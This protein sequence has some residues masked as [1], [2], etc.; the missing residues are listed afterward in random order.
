VALRGGPLL[1]TPAYANWSSSLE[2]DGTKSVWLGVYAEGRQSAQSVFHQDSYSAKVSYRPRD[3]LTFSLAAEATRYSD[4]HQF[5][6]T[7]SLQSAS[8]YIVSHLEAESRSLALRAEWHLRPELSL[9][10]YGNP[11]GSTVRFGEYRQVLAPDA[12]NFSQRLSPALRASSFNG[13]TLLDADGDGAA[14]FALDQPDWND[15]SFHSNL[16]LRWEYR[17]GSTLYLAW[18]QQRYGGNSA[19]NE[20]AWSTLTRLRSQPPS[21]QF[22]MKITYWFSS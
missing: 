20:S 14:D 19:L 8:S 1:Y 6:G 3:S 15:G 7:D 5:V 4:R 22:M 12:S 11:F 2:T 18:S 21:N 16:V 10:Y 17:L 9:Q 13:R